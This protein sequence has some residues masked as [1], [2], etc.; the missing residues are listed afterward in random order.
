MVLPSAALTTTAKL[1]AVE[2]VRPAATYGGTA[3]PLPVL[4]P[5]AGL[6]PRG[7]LRPGSVTAVS[8]S[9]AL[10]LALLAGVS[11]GG[12]WAATVGLPDLGAA[13][14]AELGMS[15]ERLACVPAPTERWAAVAGIL[16][17][18]VDAVALRPPARPRTSE[19]R[20]LLARAREHGSALLVTGNW[21]G[22]DLCLTVRSG[23]WS[24]LS[25]GHGRL[26]ARRVVVRA[27]GRG[28]AARPRSASVWLP[29]ADGGV[30]AAATS[31]TPLA[32]GG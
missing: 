3:A 24:G 30:A 32:R 20:G 25:Q 2:G 14:A 19:V 16:L 22:A 6:F 29:A 10:L 21:P 15:L 7:G 27:E 28:A 5:L 23:R 11:S 26:A 18:A 13:A 1:P 8:G 31:P 12:G 4:P 9:P 17:D